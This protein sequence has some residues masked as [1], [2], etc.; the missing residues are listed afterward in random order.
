[1]AYLGSAENRIIKSY[2]DRSTHKHKDL[3]AAI[4]L[5]SYSFSERY[6]GIVRWKLSEIQDLADVLGVNAAD[7]I[8]W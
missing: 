8:G 1:M 5:K 7:L 3:A 2:I 4:G 6:R